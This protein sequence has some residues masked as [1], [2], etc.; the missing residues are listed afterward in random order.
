[1]RS[2][3]MPACAARS[4]ECSKKP[5]MSATISTAP[6][7]T[8]RLCM[9]MTP[10]SWAAATCAMSGSP[11]RPQISLRIAAP[12]LSA[13]SATSRLL[14]VDGDRHRDLGGERLQHRQHARHL[15]LGR[16]R[17]VA[18]PRRFAAD[19]DDISALVDHAPRI[20]ERVVQRHRAAAIG[21]AVR[22][23]IEDA[24]DQRLALIGERAAAGVEYAGGRLWQGR[25]GGT[26]EEFALKSRALAGKA[27][28]RL[29]G[30]CSA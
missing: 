24:H 13:A 5:M 20:G 9:M 30:G 2:G 21:E 18:G 12:R 11:S 1:M 6:S 22:R 27:S 28:G 16:D 23:H 8:V 10:A 7:T 19:I 17:G 4:S 3:R 15:L 25:H 26:V 14:G 29:V